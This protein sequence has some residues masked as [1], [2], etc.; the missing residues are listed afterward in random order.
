M[1]RCL[2]L[3]G[4]CGLLST[5]A[6]CSG[7][8]TDAAALASLRKQYLLS[9]EPAGAVTLLTAR[10]EL[11]AEGEMVMVGFIAKVEQPFAA[12]RAVF[13]LADPTLL[14]EEEEHHHADG[15]DA[16]CPFCAR[17]KEDNSESM[18]LVEVVD[19]SGAVLRH[20][21]Q[22]LFDLAPEQV[23]VVRGKPRVDAAGHLLI[24]ASGIYVRRAAQ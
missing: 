11:P 21:A 10:E 23:V 1:L 7:E 17:K 18:A 3:T 9:E 14:C 8:S 4:I 12:D 22:P 6:G 15:C 5:A 24:A 13:V 16:H 20:G 2:L 19:A